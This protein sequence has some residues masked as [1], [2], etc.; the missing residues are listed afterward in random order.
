VA[1]A[2]SDGGIENKDKEQISTLR[3]VGKYV[4]GQVGR[5]IFSGDFNLT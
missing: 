4:L 5:K 2:Y 1:N 3:G